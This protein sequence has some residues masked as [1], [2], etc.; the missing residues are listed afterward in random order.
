MPE[1]QIDQIIQHLKRPEITEDQVEALLHRIMSI[2]E[3]SFILT[4]H[5]LE[6]LVQLDKSS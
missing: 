6:A 3:N 1:A 2:D 4:Q 5:L